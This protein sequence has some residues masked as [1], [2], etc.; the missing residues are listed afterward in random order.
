MDVVVHIEIAEKEE[1]TVPGVKGDDF[2]PFFRVLREAGYQ[3]AIS[4]EGKGTDAQIA[5]AFKEIAKQA[6]EV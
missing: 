5:P 6:G 1:R 4:I 3:G 2:R